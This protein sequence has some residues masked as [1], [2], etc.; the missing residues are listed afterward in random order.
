MRYIFGLCVRILLCFIPLS[1]FFMV[2]LPL[3]IKGTALFLYGYHPI[4]TGD[5]LLVNTRTFEFVEACVATASYYLLWVLTML[6]KGLTVVTRVK[7]IITGFALLLAMNILRIVLLILLALYYDPAVFDF[8]HLLFWKF[9]SGV[10]VAGV[11]FFIVYV[12]KVRGIPVYDDL[13]YFYMQSF[14]VRK[15]R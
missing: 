15:K 10:Y 2:L 8:V 12:F 11:W 1:L 7:M 3:T 4:V 14:F 9:L 6:T 13:K 5:L